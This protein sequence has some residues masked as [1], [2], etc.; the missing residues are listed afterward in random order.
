MKLREMRWVL[1]TMVGI[2]ILASAASAQDRPEDGRDRS[3]HAT[4]FFLAKADS[5]LFRIPDRLV[6]AQLSFDRAYLISSAVSKVLVRRFTLLG[7]GN[8]LEVEGQLGQHAGRETS[9]EADVALTLRSG[10]LGVFGG[11]SLNVAWGNGLSYAFTAPR[12]E[13]GDSGIEGVGAKRFQYYMA[14]E[15]ELTDSSAPNLHL[16]LRLAHRSGV[17]GLISSDRTGSNY[18]GAGLGFDLR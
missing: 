5:R 4:V 9:T 15:T 10:Q 18:L 8:S 11:T 16:V 2:N 7:R 12:T 3:G 14:F 1:S 17:Y 6:T 13:K